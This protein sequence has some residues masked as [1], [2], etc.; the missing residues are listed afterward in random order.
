VLRAIAVLEVLAKHLGSYT[1]LGAA[2]ASEYRGTLKRRM[3][4][5][6]AALISAA[7]GLA[8]TWMIGFVAFWD[9]RWRLAYVVVSAGVLLAFAGFA[10]YAA[11]VARPQGAASGV[12]RDELRKDR[13][14]F[15]EWTRTL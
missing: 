13:E 14:L 6:A 10:A 4:W 9:T 2:A 12:L 3:K 8:A 7:A 1:E 5:A 15:Q 11:L